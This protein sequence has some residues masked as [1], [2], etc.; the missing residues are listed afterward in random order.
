M[1]ATLAPPNRSAV[2]PAVFPPAD[3]TVADLL[4]RLGGVPAA[5]VRLHPWP[6]TATR[7]DARSANERG[8]AC[9]LIDGTLVEKRIGLWESAIVMVV[10]QLLRNFVGP[11]RLGMV[12]G[13]AGTFTVLGE[14]VRIPDVT[15]TTWARLAEADQGREVWAPHLSPDLAVEVLGPRNTAAEIARKRRE[16]FAGGTRLMWVFDRPTRTVAVYAAGDGPPAIVRGVG[17]T[18]DGDDVLPGFTLDVAGVFAE[19]EPPD[20]PI[21][22]P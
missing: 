6:G 13:E 2:S 12:A 20:G 18:V 11:R 17:D 22:Q 3:Q 4:E 7:D 15:F 21:R 9:E 16:L 1:T 19:A 8:I 5:R 14:Q 10:G